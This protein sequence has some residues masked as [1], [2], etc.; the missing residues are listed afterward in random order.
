[1]EWNKLGLD[2]HANLHVVGG[3]GVEG[4]AMV[5]YLLECGFQNITIHDHSTA[6][7]FP[8]RFSQAHLSIPQTE[9]QQL[10][11]GIL[12]S[13]VHFQYQDRYL[14][15]IE[16]ADCIFVGQNWRNYPFNF[17]GLTEAQ[18][19]GIPFRTLTE[20][21]FLLSPCPIIGVTGT[22]GKTTTADLIYHLLSREKTVHI[23]GNGIY[24]PQVLHKIHSFSSEDV[25]VLEISNRQLQDLGHSP[26]I[27]VITNL[28]EDHIEEH[29][30]FAD[31][32][33]T[34]YEIFRHQ[35]WLSTAIVNHDHP[36][37]RY[38]DIRRAKT[39]RYGVGEGADVT[40]RDGEIAI[41]DDETWKTLASVEEYKL[42][43]L[44][45]CQNALAAVA[46]AYR[47]GAS[48]AAIQEGLD[49]YRG[50]KNRLE[51][52]RQVE[53]IKFYNDMAASSPAA[54]TAALEALS[55]KVILIAGGETKGADYTDLV[56]E[57]E[58]RVEWLLL[59]EGTVADELAGRLQGQVHIHRFTELAEAVHFAY[60][61]GTDG[62][63]ILLSPGGAHFYSQYVQDGPSFV[64]TVKRLRKARWVS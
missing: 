32:V 34:K 42:P 45:N 50:V 6:D 63:K 5:L 25:L 23:A 27:A 57:I 39:I 28:E 47:A 46:A 2:L 62:T 54:T 51:F 43:G 55:D 4:A 30:S 59:L 21:Y 41:R 29:G 19:R 8:R 44:H 38:F 18:R 16:E 12:H 35:G 26:D 3:A 37:T 52:V 60:R 20:L 13:P 33:R 49:T 53:G 31:Y 24:H 9:R 58:S 11:D 7:Q 61:K 36:I 22:N 1:M 56:N 17:P 15:G 14:D 48:P 64:K 10:L 40:V